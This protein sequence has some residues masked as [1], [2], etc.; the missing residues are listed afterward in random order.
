[1]WDP[2]SAIST[3]LG[4]ILATY[5]GLKAVRIASKTITR[6]ELEYKAGRADIVL[7]KAAAITSL[8]GEYKGALHVFWK[9]Q[10]G[11]VR[12]MWVDA[13]L[14]EA[15][16]DAIAEARMSW[17]V[18]E[19]GASER[20]AHEL[21]Y[22]IKG[23][24]GELAAL[25]PSMGSDNAPGAAELLAVLDVL[26][27]SLRAQYHALISDNPWGIEVSSDDYNEQILHAMANEVVAPI[28]KGESGD[29]VKREV[30]T[31]FSDYLRDAGQSPVSPAV[32]ATLFHENFVEP[33]WKDAYESLV[34]PVHQRALTT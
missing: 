13:G 23:A 10:V 8:S 21:D 28:A 1:M 26:R 24:A 19:R 32:A 6:A 25:V 33:E 3:A 30:V 4:V 16:N 27:G 20:R 31:W 9:E 18:E 15:D 5:L 29:V 14:D 12:G 17:L 11:D 2:I 34:A 22:T 7:E